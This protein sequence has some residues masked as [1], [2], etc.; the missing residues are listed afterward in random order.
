MLPSQ[1]LGW[2]A[3]H[4]KDA[5]RRWQSLQGPSHGHLAGHQNIEI[6]DFLHGAL[7]HGPDARLSVGQP[8]INLFPF[9]RGQFFRVI[10]SRYLRAAFMEPISR[11]NHRPGQ[12]TPACL[13]QPRAD[14]AAGFRPFGFPFRGNGSAPLG[15]LRFLD[16]HIRPLAQVEKLGATGSP[17]AIDLDLFDPG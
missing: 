3:V 16:G 5:L 12:R 11:G 4:Q 9:F 17:A 6:I 10:Q 14:R 1:V 15:R 13:I 8:E 7:P 2:Q